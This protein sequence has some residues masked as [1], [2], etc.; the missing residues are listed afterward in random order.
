MAYK[1]VCL[2]ALNL[3]T[4]VKNMENNLGIRNPKFKVATKN[5]E[6]AIMAKKSSEANVSRDHQLVS[7][8]VDPRQQGIKTMGNVFF[9]SC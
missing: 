6:K 5:A 4:S 9:S 3:L 7:A 8:A 2:L 1:R